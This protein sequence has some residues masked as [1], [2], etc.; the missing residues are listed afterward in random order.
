MK[1]KGNNYKIVE[2]RVAGPC[3]DKPES[4]RCQTCI[5]DTS[6]FFRDL[7][8]TAK[9]DLQPFLKLKSFTSKEMLYNEGDSCKNL[10]I[11]LSGEVKIYKSMH[12][13]KHQIH[14]LVHIPGDL[15]ACD[16][17]FLEHH[18][19]S[20]ESIT[21]VGTCYIN[22]NEFLKH[23]NKNSDISTAMMRFMSRNINSYIRHIANLGQK[24]ALA[25]VASYIFFLYETHLEQHLESSL[26]HN[27]LSRIEL[28]EMLGVTQRT[29]IRSLK[30]L[31]ENKLIT[32]TKN[33]F[34]VL[35]IEKL[36]I[37]SES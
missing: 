37:L 33:G 27:S 6:H 12:S 19:S 26:L 13:G 34:L 5:M 36:K 31:E 29:L 7:D 28:S 18:G 14:K 8:I 11:L 17:L 20:A 16:D 2:S 30:Q 22:R 21:D 4:I 1:I 32:I 35:D 15:I 3:M 24:N 9:K 25:R 10:Y 23:L